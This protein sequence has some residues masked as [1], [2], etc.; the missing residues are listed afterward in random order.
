[1]P[2]IQV[3]WA[4]GRSVDQKR[5]LVKK[6]T[7]AVVEAGKCPPEAVSVIIRDLPKTNIGKAGGLLADK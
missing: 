6:I 5:E 1:M 2:L 4:E 3:D 7:Q